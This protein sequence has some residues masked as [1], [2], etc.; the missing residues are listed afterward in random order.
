MFFGKNF[1][2][3]HVPHEKLCTTALH[4]QTMLEKVVLVFICCI[5]IVSNILSTN[6][7]YIRILPVFSFSAKLLYI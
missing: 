2:N 6:N 7:L 1:Y 3:V 4:K 5:C